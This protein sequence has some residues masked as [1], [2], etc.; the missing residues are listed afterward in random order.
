[1]QAT[2]THLF[3][4]WDKLVSFYRSSRRRWKGWA[5]RGHA[6]AKWTLASSLE[7]AAVERFRLSLAVLPE[8]ERKLLRDF[9]RQAHHLIQGVPDFKDRLGWLALMQHHGA[10]TR[11]LDWTYSFY[12]AAFFAI[13]KARPEDTCTVWAIDYGWCRARIRA[14][15]RKQLGKSIPRKMED[16]LWLQ[17]SIP[18]VYPVNPFRLNQRLITQQGVFIAPGDITMSFA[19]NLTAMGPPRRRSPLR[20]LNIRCTSRFLRDAFDDLR[21]MNVTSAALFPG[22]D[23]FARHLETMIPVIHEI[24]DDDSPSFPNSLPNKRLQP[25][26]RDIQG[27]H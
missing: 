24:P 26:G 17:P 11:L 20:R 16:L 6:S 8:L 25:T 23:G 7:R 5:F 27:S 9:Q 15:A 2:D 10:P 13:E 1:M 12:A 19:D 22:L 21:R 14:A 18:G 3:D 4:R